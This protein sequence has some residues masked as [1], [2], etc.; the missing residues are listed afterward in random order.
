MGQIGILLCSAKSTIKAVYTRENKPRTE[1]F[2][3]PWL[4]R[5]CTFRL[6]EQ[7]AAYI[8]RG[9]C[10]SRLIFPRMNGPTTCFGHHI[11]TVQKRRTVL[12]GDGLMTYKSLLTSF[13]ILSE[14]LQ[15]SH[16][17]F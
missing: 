14:I 4:V 8:S 11:D 15:V 7:F 6:Y 1:P 9:L 10:N 16:G 13:L 17:H 12:C 2:I 5:G 3:R